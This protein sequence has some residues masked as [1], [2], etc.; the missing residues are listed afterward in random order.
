[1]V[2]AR[3]VREG[4][5]YHDI[6]YQYENGDA[7]AAVP[8]GIAPITVYPTATENTVLFAERLKKE[9]SIRDLKSVAKKEPSVILGGAGESLVVLQSKGQG[10]IKPSGNTLTITVDVSEL[11]LP[12]EALVGQYAGE[13]LQFSLVKSCTLFYT[14][15]TGRVRMKCQFDSGKTHAPPKQPASGRGLRTNLSGG[16]RTA[17]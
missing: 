16:L 4:D 7:I 15:S 10:I 6:K 12:A 2:T 1:M 17:A 5:K 11:G 3:F 8:H 13:N 14:P 9:Y